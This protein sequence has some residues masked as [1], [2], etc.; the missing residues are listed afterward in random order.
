MREGD[1]RERGVVSFDCLLFLASEILELSDPMPPRPQ[2][3]EG[4]GRL[5]SDGLDARQE[6]S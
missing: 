6:E 4:R 3:G 5:A 1:I 2:I